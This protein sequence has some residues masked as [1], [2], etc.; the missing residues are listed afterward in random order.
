MH[1][2]KTKTKESTFD[3]RRQPNE[4]SIVTRYPVG[5]LTPGVSEASRLRRFS[6]G[7]FSRYVLLKPL[8]VEQNSSYR[9]R[10]QS[11]EETAYA[12]Y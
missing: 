5:T 11:M 4:E 9:D 8:R 12:S 6:G 10:V 2:L 1:A 7:R 3:R